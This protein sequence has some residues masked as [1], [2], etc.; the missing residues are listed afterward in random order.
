MW[1]EKY[2]KKNSWSRRVKV[3]NLFLNIWNGL[4]SVA[5]MYSMYVFQKMWNRIRSNHQT[6]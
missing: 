3:K 1:I 6:D 5:S 4:D 2:P